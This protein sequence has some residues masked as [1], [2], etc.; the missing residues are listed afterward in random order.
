MIKYPS[1]KT[2]WIGLILFGVIAIVIIPSLVMPSMSG[3]E[4]WIYHIINAAV[5]IFLLWMWFDT[6]YWLSVSELKFRSGPWKG[7]I[8]VS[9]IFEIQENKYLWVGYRPALATGGL[10]IRYNKYDEIY[11]SPQRQDEFVEKLMSYNPT[12]KVITNHKN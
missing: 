4:L 6:S 11:I 5:L 1:R 8:E 9:Q 10:I 12:I 2:W 3:D 7:S